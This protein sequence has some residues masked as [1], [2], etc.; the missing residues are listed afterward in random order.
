M[1]KA[2]RPKKTSHSSGLLRKRI[3]IGHDENGK[4]IR[5][6]VYAKTE[7][8]L[9]EKVRHFQGYATRNATRI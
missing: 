8:E 3:T 6:P 9:E 2:G 7:A 1:G 5:K 4:P